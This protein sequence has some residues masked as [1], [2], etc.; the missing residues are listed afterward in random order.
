MKSPY[1]RSAY[2]V[3]VR[4]SLIF[5]R[6]LELSEKVCW[7]PEDLGLT[8]VHIHPGQSREFE[9][10]SAL[11]AFCAEKGERISEDSYRFDWLPPMKDLSGVARERHLREKHW[12]NREQVVNTLLDTALQAYLPD[13]RRLLSAMTNA[14]FGNAELVKLDIQNTPR[15]LTG[16]PDTAFVDLK[17]GTIALIEIKIGGS[18]GSSTTRF[19]VAQ[20]VKYETLAALLSSERFFPGFSS[21]KVLLGPHSSF[22]KNANKAHLLGPSSDSEGWVGFRYDEVALAA[23]KPTG[24]GRGVDLVRARLKSISKG[25]IQWTSPGHDLGLWFHSWPTVAG[26]A[27]PGLLRENLEALMKN[28]S[29][30]DG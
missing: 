21:H 3:E 13:S 27:P 23:L 15:A 2:G 14:E 18:D 5:E 26:M 6:A 19:S 16:A 30:G 17:S 20:S 22:S 8:R 9:S 29:P 12:L 7:N 1:D 24:H 28:L 4:S 11:A 10:R 25:E